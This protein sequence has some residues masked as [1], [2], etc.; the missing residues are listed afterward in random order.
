MTSPLQ[1]FPTGQ[2]GGDMWIA[3]ITDA[4]ALTAK[5]R[6]RNL[7]LAR[8]FPSGRQVSVAGNSIEHRTPGFTAGGLSFARA[9]ARA[10]EMGIGNC[11]WLVVRAN[12]LLFQAILTMRF[13]RSRC[14]AFE[15]A[16]ATSAQGF[17]RNEPNQLFAAFASC[18]DALPLDVLKEG[19]LLWPVDLPEAEIVLVDGG[20]LGAFFLRWRRMPSQ[21]RAAGRR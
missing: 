20:H 18:A 16:D 21:R 5:R 19:A 3:R 13:H 6:S 11:R 14:A 15:G 2:I 7:S 1:I 12:F 8:S 9:A 17:R 4:Q 10:N